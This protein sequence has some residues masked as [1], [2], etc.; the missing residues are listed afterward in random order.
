MGCQVRLPPH[1]PFH[2]ASLSPS[3]ILHSLCDPATPSTSATTLQS[4][5]HQRSVYKAALVSVSGVIDQ[6]P[7][8]PIFVAG[9][10][11]F[12]AND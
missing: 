5:S 6:F 7:T 11:F 4:F 8:F 1:T 10:P 2:S 12:Q 9:R 3:A